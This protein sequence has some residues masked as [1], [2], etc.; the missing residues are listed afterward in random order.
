MKH[1][2][3][4]LLPGWEEALGRRLSA[5]ELIRMSAYIVDA[6]SL[7]AVHMYKSVLGIEFQRG[8]FQWPPDEWLKK[9]QAKRAPEV[10]NQ[11]KTDKTAKKVPVPD[12]GRQPG[13]KPGSGCKPT[14]VNG[15]SLQKDA[16]NKRRE[17]PETG[18]QP[19]ATHDSGSLQSDHSGRS[20]PQHPPQRPSFWLA[21]L[22]SRFEVGR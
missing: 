6:A 10:D 9:Y 5:L 4:A 17:T 21:N 14:E 2:L 13:A 22:S 12:S 11:L 1:L 19:H 3:D 20:M 7:N 15:R 18:S 16:G 8:V